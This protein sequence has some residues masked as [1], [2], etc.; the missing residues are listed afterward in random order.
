VDG[1][2]GLVPAGIAV[3]LGVPFISQVAKVVDLT[4]ES[5]TVWRALDEGRQVVRVP[6]PAVISVS[7]EINE[8]RYP[9]FMGVRK[10]SRMQYPTTCANDLPGLDVGR[11]GAGVALTT[12]THLRKP[13]ARQNR[14]QFIE[15]A[16]APE[17]A[18]ALVERLVAEKVV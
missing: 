16:T 1:N 18:A 5:I 8:P 9:N 3:K 13:L 6:L 2:S 17:K 15:G 12:W 10:A 4:G 11:V 7:K 14:C